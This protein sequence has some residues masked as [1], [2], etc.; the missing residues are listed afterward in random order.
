M[1]CGAGRV[2]TLHPAV[3][4]GILAIRDK[5]EHM[6]ALETHKIGTIDLV[7]ANLYPFRKTVTANP[8]PKFE[9]RL[10]TAPPALCVTP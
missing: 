6:Q 1:W 2:K 8:P 5:P 9:V 4:G 3:H 7:V 10:P